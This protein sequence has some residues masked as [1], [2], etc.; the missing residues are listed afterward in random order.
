MT[1]KYWHILLLSMSY[2]ATVALFFSCKHDVIYPKN[3]GYP[4]T[5]YVSY[6]PPIPPPQ[7]K[8]CNPDSVYFNNQILPILN[9][10]CN[11]CH[12]TSGGE[13]NFSLAS[14]TSIMYSGLVKA[15]NPANSRLYTSV[16]KN[17]G[18][19]RMPPSPRTPLTQAQIDLI[20][21][22]IQQGAK[23]LTCDAC[24]TSK[25]TYSGAIFPVIQTYCLGCHS[26]SNPSG[27]VSL[28]NYADVIVQ[29]NNGHLMCDINQTTTNCPNMH[30][31]PLGGT[32]LTDCV[33]T[34]FNKWI[35][36]GEKN[37]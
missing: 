23:N 34:Q 32:K 20:Y 11:M 27:S 5:P 35:K 37:N 13:S 6:T 7:G 19:D 10:N 14:Y 2:I 22:W 1:K 31:M 4:G 18:E 33:I 21:K 36:D 25:Y 9:S 12:S 29:L 3:Y 28:V 15:G 8:Q 17:G 24:D 16:T 26:G 30:A